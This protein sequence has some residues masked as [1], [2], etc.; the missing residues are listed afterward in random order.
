VVKTLPWSN[1]FLNEVRSVVEALDG[2]PKSAEKMGGPDVLCRAFAA[3]VDHTLLKPEAQP[4][5]VR[6]ACEE[7]SRCA[8]AAMVVNPCYVPL[9][10][11]CLKGTGVAVATVAGFPLGAA[12]ADVKRREAEQG[13]EDGAREVDM[14]VRVGALK[15]GEDELVED[16]IRELAETCHTKRATLKVILECALL[17]D[18]EK[19]RGARLVV[20]AAAD[21]VKTST[22]F[23][24]GGATREDVALLR[25]VVG[26]DAGVKAAGGIRTLADAASMLAAGASRLGMSSSVSVLD[27]LRRRATL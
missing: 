21:F 24:P 15:A 9:A 12:R 11:Q 26:S 19:E 3:L 6:R 18:A 2:L 16:E 27:E 13:L 7:A 22:G 23:G 10:A 17:T 14:V 5:D 8:F 20:R 1:S 25:A 4:D